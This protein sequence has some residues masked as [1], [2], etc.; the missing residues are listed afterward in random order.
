[1]NQRR[2][3]ALLPP[4]ALSALFAL[5]IS[6]RCAAGPQSLDKALLAAARQNDLAHAKAFLKAGAD[7][8]CRGAV[9]PSYTPL[10]VAARA[11]NRPMARLLLDDKADVNLLGGDL[12]HDQTALMLAAASGRLDMLR[13]LFT[14]GAA[15]NARNDDSETAL[16]FALNSAT[17]RLLID[18]GADV[19]AKTEEFADT[20]LMTAVGRGN[21]AIVRILLSHGAAANAE[22][23]QGATALKIAIA[24]NKSRII[25]LLERAGS[26][27][28]RPPRL[29]QRR[30]VLR[31]Y[32]SVG[33]LTYRVRY[34]QGAEDGLLLHPSCWPPPIWLR[35]TRL[36]TA[37]M[38]VLAQAAKSLNVPE[39]C[40]PANQALVMSL[41]APE[42]AYYDAY[43]VQQLMAEKKT[44]G[45]PAEATLTFG[46]RRRCDHCS[47][48]EQQAP[49]VACTLMGGTHRWSTGSPQV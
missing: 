45:V 1:M 23:K 17:A 34:V 2:P 37:Y 35:K 31:Y 20:V 29:E 10:M 8:N 12:P 18:H 43:K 28:L 6:D 7:P 16:M 3:K 40:R 9:G 46:P 21:A 22:N 32:R 14:R 11:G 33:L 13:L 38:H 26:R 49:P 15:V 25:R 42:R 41:T 19:N 27:H 4:L 30:E 5:S 36:Q 44:P 24:G 48:D 39:A 47:H